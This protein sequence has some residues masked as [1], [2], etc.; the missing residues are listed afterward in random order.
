MSSSGGIGGGGLHLKYLDS[1]LD[2]ITGVGF[3]LEVMTQLKTVLR[4]QNI[5]IKLNSAFEDP[6]ISGS[7]IEGFKTT[8]FREN[9]F[10]DPVVTTEKLARNSL[11]RPYVEN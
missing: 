9:F 2:K 1:V 6:K 10:K 5:A 3:S 11:T 4:D 8:V 7:F